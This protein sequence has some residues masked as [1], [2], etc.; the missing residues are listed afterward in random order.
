MT[1]KYTP[2]DEIFT[3]KHLSPVEKGLFDKLPGFEKKHAVVVAQKMVLSSYQYPELDREKLVK[4]GLLHDIGKIT[5][6]NSVLAKSA[7]VIFRFFF[8][9]LYNYF[10]NL[11]E[12]NPIFKRYYVHKHHGAIGAKILEKNGVSPQFFSIIKKHDPRIEPLGPEDPLELKILQQ[13]DS[14]Y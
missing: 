4:L 3:V 14:T 5:E 6:R 10:A 12:S 9:R 13:A 8:P 2:E 11:G 1:A 7:F